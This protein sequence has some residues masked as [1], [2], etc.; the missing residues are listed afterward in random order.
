MSHHQA[1]PEPSGERFVGVREAAQLLGITPATLRAWERRHGTPRPRRAANGYRLYSRADL[2][3]LRRIKARTDDGVRV[4]LAVEGLVASHSPTQ[5]QGENAFELH[6]E[7]LRQAVLRYDE[8]EAVDV[9]RQALVLYP[10]EDVMVSLIGRTMTWVGTEWA[11]GR[12]SIGVEHFVSALFLRQLLLLYSASPDPW[13]AGRVIGACAP[14]DEHEIG[15]LMLLVGLRRRGWSVRYLG[16]DLPI[17]ELETAAAALKSHVILVSA[18]R[19]LEDD[20]LDDLA[21]LPGRLVDPRPELILGG[22]SFQDSEE[23]PRGVVV[24]KALFDESLMMLENV[25]LRKTHAI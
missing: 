17:G 20:V 21:A 23:E 25:L 22:Q 5:V 7:R 11:A 16:P 9:L 1:S 3:T 18:T 19:R 4:G 13:R 2:E 14:G 24:L 12:L 15:L 10:V 8:R 6:S